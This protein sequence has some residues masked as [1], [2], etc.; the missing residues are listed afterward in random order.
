MHGFFCYV[1]LAFSSFFFDFFFFN[2]L[3]YTIHAQIFQVINFKNS[4]FNKQEINMICTLISI[5]SCLFFQFDSSNSNI[6][7][8]GVNVPYF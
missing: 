7:V 1:Y 2:F 4:L 5:S 6:V 8:Y 3:P